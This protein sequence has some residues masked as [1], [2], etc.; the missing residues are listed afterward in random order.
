MIHA[1]IQMNIK[2]IRFN[3]KNQIPPEWEYIRSD[4]IYINSWFGR[5]PN[6]LFSACIWWFQDFGYNHG[7]L[8][9]LQAL[10][11]QCKSDHN[12]CVNKWAW[13][14]S[15]KTLFTKMTSWPWPCSWPTPAAEGTNYF[16]TTEHR[17]ELT[18]GRELWEVRGKDLKE[19][20]EIWGGIPALTLFT[21]VMDL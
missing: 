21:V 2:I 17:S 6:K 8:V 4:S 15:N 7:T 5:C 12:Q 10:L 1:A 11:W 16:I 18:R 3:K 13:L 9:Q 20:E 19:Q 14:C